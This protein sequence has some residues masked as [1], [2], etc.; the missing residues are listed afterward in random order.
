MGTLGL[1]LQ[2]L[3][4]SGNQQEGSIAGWVYA[5]GMEIVVGISVLLVVLLVCAACR[6]TKANSRGNEKKF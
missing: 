3:R 6:R 5:Y 1:M 2:S 4:V